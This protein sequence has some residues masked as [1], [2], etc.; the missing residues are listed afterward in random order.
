MKIK[1]LTD[2]A[3]L[4]N[5]RLAKNNVKGFDDE[6]RVLHAAVKLNEEVGELCDAVLSHIGSQRGIK[7]AAH[8]PRHLENEIADAILAT[9]ILAQLVEVDMESALKSKMVKI[10]SRYDNTGM[11]R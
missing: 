2:Y 11:E 7:N 1:E 9:A 6:K 5:D 3:A 10:D 4:A 8:S